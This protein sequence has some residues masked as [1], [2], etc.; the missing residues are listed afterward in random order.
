MLDASTS[1]RPTPLVDTLLPRLHGARVAVAQE[2]TLTRLLLITLGSLVALG[3]HTMSQVLV[4]F[5]GGRHEWS[6]W[7]R[8]FN[9]GRVGIGWL[10]RDV[11]RSLLTL[12]APGAPLVVVLDATQ[13]PRS[14]RRFPGGGWTKA[15][16]SPKWRPGLHVAQR[17]ELLSGLLP[18]SD[19][20]ESRTVPLR[21]TYLRS[22]KTTPIGLVP[23]QSECAAGG[24]LL[25]WLEVILRRDQH[26]PHPVLVLAD[27][28]YST[29]PMVNRLPAAMWLFARCAK[30]RALFA[31]PVHDPHRRGRKRVYGERGPTP[32][33]TLH[34]RA[35]WQSVSVTV[36]GRPILLTATVTGPWLIHGAPTHPLMLVVV[37]GIDRGHGPTRRQRDPQYFLV[38]AHLTDGTW[39]LP[40]PLAEL[41]AWAW[42]RWEVAV[43]HRELKSSFGFGDQQA[44]SDRG[45][46]TTMAWVLWVYAL[47]ILTGYQVWGLGPAPGPDLGRWWRP[48]RWSIGRLLQEFRAELWQTGEFQPTWGRSPDAWGEMGA[49]MATQ[50]TAALGQRHL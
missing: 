29:A 43:M 4:A 31:L 18:R 36:R 17:V 37:K 14:S 30:N 32:Q 38:S 33:E 12:L 27:G 44:W 21:A 28:A 22:A 7:Y 2:R 42:Q 13:V 20:G 45:A 35:S 40:L 5:G 16:R 41:L 24:S 9:R 39:C 26:P 47:L 19:T 23:E 49:W 8:L 10:E 3:R 34:R 50:T 6:A 15:P 11:L 48:R 1:R 25:R 46:A